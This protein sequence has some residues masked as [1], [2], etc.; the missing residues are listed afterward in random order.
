MLMPY[1]IVTY[2][3][4]KTIQLSTV[5]LHVQNLTSIKKVSARNK[6]SHLKTYSSL[7]TSEPNIH[8]NFRSSQKCQLVD[9]METKSNKI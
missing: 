7:S 1:S 8:T 4:L 9:S 2:A 3:D 6:Y 5:R